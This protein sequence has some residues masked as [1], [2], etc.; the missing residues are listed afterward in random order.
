MKSIWSCLLIGVS[1]GVVRRDDP[2]K[3][4]VSAI[5]RTTDIIH[6]AK[7]E[8]LKPKINPQAKRIKITYGPFMIKG[9]EDKKK[10]GNAASLDPA[11]TGYN[12][13][14]APK[15]LP[16]DI[17]VLQGGT[18]ITENGKQTVL[19]G[20]LYNHHTVFFNINKR[21]PR[22]LACSN[23]VAQDILPMSAFIAGATEVGD[24]TYSD[25]KSNTGYYIGKND[26]IVFNLDIVNYTNNTREV[27][28]VTE[29]EYIPGKPAGLMDATQQLIDPTMCDGNNSG[30]VSGGHKS[31][32][33]LESK[34]MTFLSDGIF[35]QPRGHLHDGGAY[36][37]VTIN[38]KQLCD[39]EALYGGP[40]HTSKTPD[41]KIW[42]TL[43][44]TTVCKNMNIKKGD[45]MF[46]VA[47][48]DTEKHPAREQPHG[49]M[50]ENMAYLVSSFALPS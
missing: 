43:R 21:A 31:R 29:M 25:G 18:I 3:D 41:G 42:E 12:Y 35:I 4:S 16:R 2:G 48:Y 10:Y 37:K 44:E 46:V 13:L 14:A 26:K 47:A 8:E 9:L 19:K 6:A 39:S 27:V 17:T 34:E 15:D 50:A 24:M 20:G 5:M 30:L 7:V 11:G 45:K 22:I 49:T 1:A 40:D 23:G 38:G 36:L 32:F 33:T 28:S